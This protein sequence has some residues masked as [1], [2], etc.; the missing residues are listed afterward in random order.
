MKRWFLIRHV[1]YWYLRWRVYRHAAFW[2][3]AGIG[4]CVNPADEEMLER[5]WRG[6]A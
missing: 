2:I 6:E 3:E 1:R 4:I 5:I